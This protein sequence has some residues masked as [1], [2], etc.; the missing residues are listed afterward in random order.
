MGLLRVERI[1]VGLVGGE[2]ECLVLN[3][4]ESAKLRV[5]EGVGGNGGLV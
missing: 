5:A 1:R 4:L 3:P 2:P